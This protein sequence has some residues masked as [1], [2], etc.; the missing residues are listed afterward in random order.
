[1]GLD[2][3]GHRADES[4]WRWRRVG[5]TDLQNLSDQGR[6]IWYP[7]PHDNPSAGTGHT[8]H[9]LGYIERLRGKHRTED[10]DDEIECLVR[11]ASKIGGIAFLESE[12][13]KTLLLGTPVPGLNEVAR[14]VHA[15]NVRAKFRS[16]QGCRTVA[17]SKIQD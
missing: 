11:H 10:T 16:R 7:V 5:G 14:D 13:L 3:P 2:S 8:N 6:V 1:M 12:I 15:Q 9:L 4:F 17:T